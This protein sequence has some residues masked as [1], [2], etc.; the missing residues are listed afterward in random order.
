MKNA[1]KVVYFILV[2][3]ALFASIE[4]TI[5]ILQLVPFV[6]FSVMGALHIWGYKDLKV[7]IVTLGVIMTAINL[8]EPWSPVDVILWGS[9][10]VFFSDIP[11]MI[12]KGDK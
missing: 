9:V 12:N 11:M 1:Q 5:D 6:I 4:P 7:A 3:V 10:V 2:I 8:T